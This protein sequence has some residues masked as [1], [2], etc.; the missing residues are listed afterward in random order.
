VITCLW[1][2]LSNAKPTVTQKGAR[3]AGEI[4]PDLAFKHEDLFTSG[5]DG[6][7]D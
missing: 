3:P 6:Y 5:Y 4:F 7:E 1:T 2:S